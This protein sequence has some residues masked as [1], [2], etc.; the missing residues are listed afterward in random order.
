VG[1]SFDRPLQVLPAP[2]GRTLVMEQGGTIRDLQSG[3]VFVD[4][5]SRVERGGNEQGLLGAAFHPDGTRLYVHYNEDGGDTVVAECVVSGNSAGSC[6]K[7]VDIDQPSAN[8]NG[9]SL[10]FGP[11]GL[12]L[13]LGDGGG[14]GDAGDR[15]ENT[16][17]PL[18]SILR[19]DASTPGR[20][21]AKGAGFDDA[22]IWHYGLRNPYRIHFDNGLLF[23]ADV[24]QSAREEI[25]IVRSS[26]SGLHF[27]WDTWEGTA[28][29]EGNDRTSNMVFPQV[30]HSHNEGVCAIIGG[31]VYR[32]SAIPGLVGAYLYSDNCVS[33]LRGF[34][35]DGGIRSARAFDVS[36]DGA[37]G[38]GHDAASEMY[39]TAFGGVFKIV[40]DQ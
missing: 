19:F 9:G 14:G 32:G 20:L 23:V 10:V 38:F 17:N 11:G 27:G 28:Q 4:I 36:L 3:A 39:V 37:L 21:T 7:L 6:D 26:R 13:A 15:A 12:Y 35:Y 24:G 31:E 25:T 8:H 30:E 5:S 29:F 33:F 18:G 40:P 1:G 16:G 22:R 2:N 34:R